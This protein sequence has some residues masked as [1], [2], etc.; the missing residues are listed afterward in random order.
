MQTSFLTKD[1]R[2]TR[3]GIGPSD[4]CRYLGRLW[5]YST[6]FENG[7]VL[8]SVE[9][10]R[11][12]EFEPLEWRDVTRK[13]DIGVL[14]ILY[15]YHTERNAILRLQEAKIF[16][17]PPRV[18]LRARMVSE[19]LAAEFDVYDTGVK[20][21][22]SDACIAKFLAVF[23][24][25]CEEQA[26]EKGG[27]GL[28]FKKEK[29]SP[30]QFRRL[31]KRFEQGGLDPR[32]LLPR[33]KGRS[34]PCITYTPDELVFHQKHAE[35]YL[36]KDK[37]TMKACWEEMVG[38]NL[39][40]V[41]AG[42]A[43]LNLPSLRSFQRMINEYGDFRKEYA[44]SENKHRVMRKF[45][46]AQKGL[47]VKRPLQIIEMDEHEMDL[48]RLLNRNG[49]WQFLHPDVQKRIE[50]R[51]RV[52]MS[53]ALDAWSRSV[54]GLNILYAEPDADAAVATLAM[55]AQDKNNIAALAGTTCEWP[56]AGQPEDIHTDAGSGYIADRFQVAAMAF[57]GRAAIPPSKH[58]HLRARVERFFRT[59]NQRYI[60]MFS[61]QTFSNVLLRDEYDAEKH[62]HMTHDELCS[63]LVR[64]I[65]E[66]YHNTPHRGLY[67]LTPLEAWYWGS[68]YADGAVRGRPGPD[69][70]RE[71]FG[72]TDTRKIGNRGIQILNLFYR[73][74]EL[75]ALRKRW[76][77]AELTIRINDQD[78]SKISVK[79]L[80]TN[81]WMDVGCTSDG[82]EGVSLFEWME[83]IRHVKRKF[84]RM[85]MW[86]QDKMRI[87]LVDVREA[88][89]QSKVAAKISTP[90]VTAREVRDFE[91]KEIAT[92]RYSQRENIDLGDPALVAPAHV[93]VSPGE[94]P[95]SPTGNFEPIPGLPDPARAERSAPR[96]RKSAKKPD[97]E[98]TQSDLGLALSPDG[99][100]QK[101]GQPEEGSSVDEAS[102]KRRTGRRPLRIESN[103]KDD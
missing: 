89:R 95:F 8:R 77:N 31:I 76:L 103:R 20:V 91:E 70:Y 90:G 10:D 38:Q 50:D 83:T 88:S 29:P 68:Q 87:G 96:G 44:R 55:V 15:D 61:G 42:E 45:I 49:I 39:K 63:L 18:I 12:V 3:Y 19:F 74:D 85:A 27:N 17:L 1:D 100:D 9:E 69:R 33:Y 7:V 93:P 36:T 101:I 40:R 21:S 57:T 52:W 46:I 48:V 41:K 35:M 32:S 82:L 13:V 24:A 86:Y 54:C 67:G 59:I 79:N 4:R 65:V 14:E 28:N 62:A 11:P 58:P 102:T 56:Q 53:V 47:Q 66:C 73:S 25:Q 80:Y 72:L 51:R 98:P 2:F 37:L 94:D 92:N 30:R 97:R 99:E 60:H 75:Q 78:M 26:P 6:E 16:E 84:G 23:I 81:K 34:A 43:S 22:R 71:I 64:L 5:D